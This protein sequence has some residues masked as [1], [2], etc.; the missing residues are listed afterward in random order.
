MYI[1]R[2]VSIETYTH[3]YIPVEMKMVLPEILMEKARRP[4]F[5]TRWPGFGVSKGIL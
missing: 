3:T 1:N 2:Y 5:G 4:G